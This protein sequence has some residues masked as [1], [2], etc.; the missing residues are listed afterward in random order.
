M[1]CLTTSHLGPAQPKVALVELWEQLAAAGNRTK[2]LAVMRIV[3]FMEGEE[4][5]SAQRGEILTVEAEVFCLV[6]ALTKA[7]A[8]VI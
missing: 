7:V 8:V 5:A 4:E 2:E 3:V 6:E 1:L